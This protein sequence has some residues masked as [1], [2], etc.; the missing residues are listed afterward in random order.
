[1]SVNRPRPAPP[2]PGVVCV[3]GR[4]GRGFKEVEE[5][6]PHQGSWDGSAEAVKILLHVKKKKKDSSTRKRRKAKAAETSQGEL[7]ENRAHQ[8]R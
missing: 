6:A 7:A 1:M 2:P 4:T 8:L 5:K 3:A